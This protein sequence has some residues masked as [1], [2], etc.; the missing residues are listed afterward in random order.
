MKLS[1]KNSK[2]SLS[3]KTLALCTLISFISAQAIVPA[4]TGFAMPTGRQAQNSNAPGG[5]PVPV[6][7]AQVLNG[8]ITVPPELGKIEE[9]FQGNT[10]KTILF[11]QDA[12]DS[13]EAQ[14][15]IARLI[16][17]FVKKNGIKT[18][19]EEGYEGPVPTDKFFGFIKDPKIKQKVSYFLLDKLR[20]GGA[21]YAH[22]NRT[23]DFD[24][25][26][27]D[28]LKLYSEN[29]KAYQDSSKNRKE[30]EDD[31]NELFAQISVLANQYFPKELKSWLRSKERCSKGELPLLDYFKALHSLYLKTDTNSSQFL[32]EYPALSILFA[33]E[34]TKDKKLIVQLN[35]LDS[36]VVFGEMSRLEEK[37]SNAFLQNKR[38]KKI[39]D[40]YQGLSLLKRLNQIQLTQSEYDAAKETLQNFKT[41]ELA[42]FIISLTHK[43]L[44]LSKE[45]ERHIKDAVQFYNVAQTR[46]QSINEHLKSFIKDGKED[47]AALVF[48]GFHATVIK[49]LLKEQGLNYV[50]IFPRIT[51][52]DKIHQ[53]YYRELMSVGHYSFETPFL[54]T[55]ANRPPSVLYTA[56]VA[57]D[58]SLEQE[59]KVIAMAVM[60]L[61]DYAAPQLIEQQLAIS[62]PHERNFYYTAATTARNR[63]ETR[64][65]PQLAKRLKH[66]VDFPN[67]LLTSDQMREI[68]TFVRSGALKL[69]GEDLDVL[70]VSEG[71]TRIVGAIDGMIV[72]LYGLLH[73]SVIVFVVMPDKKLLIMQR[74]PGRIIPP[75]TDR[76][77]PYAPRFSTIGGHPFS[78]ES[79]ERGMKRELVEEIGFPEGWKLEGEM[80]RCGD[81]GVFISPSSD[82]KNRERRSVYIYKPSLHEA[83]IIYERSVALDR[84]KRERS[85][86]EFTQWLHA[87]QEDHPGHGEA[88]SFET[89]PFSDVMEIINGKKIF[90]DEVY[91]NGVKEKVQVI[92]SEDVLPILLK[93]KRIRRFLPIGRSELRNKILSWTIQSAVSNMEKGFVYQCPRT[94]KNLNDFDQAWYD[95]NEMV[96]KFPRILERAS[97]E[98]LPVV[99]IIPEKLDGYSPLADQAPWIEGVRTALAW[100][101][102][103]YRTPS[104]GQADVR[105]LKVPEGFEDEDIILRGALKLFEK[106]IV[107][108][109]SPEDRMAQRIFSL[110]DLVNGEVDKVSLGRLQVKPYTMPQEPE[111]SFSQ[112]VVPELP[113]LR[114][115]QK[116]IVIT[117]AAGLIGV[118][119]IK[120]LLEEGHQVIALD[121]LSR[122]TGEFLTPFLDDSNFYF[123]NLDVSSPFDIQGPVHRVVHLASLAS[124]PDN[125]K[126]PLET[127]RAGLHGTLIT[128]DLARRKGARFLFASSS[129]IY[130]NSKVRPTPETYPGNADAYRKR[131]AYVQS[132]RGGE[133]LMKIYADRWG[134]SVDLRIARIFNVYGPQMQPNDGRVVMNFIQRAMEGQPL[135]V[136]GNN[137]ITRSFNYIDDAVD[138]LLRLL[139]TDRLA[140]GT[141]LE[142]RVF[143]IGNP[144]EITLHELARSV[145]ALAQ[146][147]FGW[148]IPITVVKPLDPDDPLKRQ[149]DITRAQTI[150]DYVPKTS[151]QEGLK[152]TL[153]HFLTGHRRSE[154]RNITQAK[155]SQAILLKDTFK[156]QNS[157]A[158]S[159]RKDVPVD[160]IKGEEQLQKMELPL[161][162]AFFVETEQS[163][164]RLF[165]Y[166][167]VARRTLPVNI[168]VNQIL[169]GTPS[170]QVR[171]K[172]LAIAPKM[173]TFGM[174]FEVLQSEDSDYSDL[175]YRF[176][177]TAMQQGS[178]AVVMLNGFIDYSVDH[179]TR[180]LKSLLSATQPSVIVSH[181]DKV[182]KSSAAAEGPVDFT[183]FADPDFV[184]YRKHGQSWLDSIKP[185]IVLSSMI[186][187]EYRVHSGI[188][189]VDQVSIGGQSARWKVEPFDQFALIP[190]HPPI[191]ERTPGDLDTLLPENETVLFIEPHQDDYALR[192]SGLLQRLAR[193]G[194]HLNVTHFESVTGSESNYYWPPHLEYRDE[195]NRGA[196]SRLGASVDYQ[197]VTVPS[198]VQGHIDQEIQL[199]EEELEKSHANVLVIPGPDDTHRH[200]ARIRYIA[201]SAAQQLVNRTGRPLKI[202]SVPLFSS[203]QEGFRKINTIIRLSD[204]EDQVRREALRSYTSQKPYV[205]GDLFDNR[206]NGMQTV[207]RSLMAE[208][209]DSTKG[210]YLE[211]FQEH[212]L[213]PAVVLERENL[214][215][216]ILSNESLTISFREANKRFAFKFTKGNKEPRFMID[217]QETQALTVDELII[218]NHFTAAFLS[219]VSEMDPERGHSSVSEIET[220]A[221]DMDAINW[222][223]STGAVGPDDTER[224][225]LATAYREI[226][227]RIIGKIEEVKMSQVWFQ[228]R[229]RKF[230]QNKLPQ[231][232]ELY[233]TRLK[234]PHK[235]VIGI[236]TYNSAELI[237][238]RLENIRNQIM[239]LPA[240]CH[241]WQVEIVLYSNAKPADVDEMTSAMIAQ[242]PQSFFDGLPVR[243]TIVIKKEPF[244][245]QANALHR[246]YEYAKQ[247]DADMVL[248]TDD[249]VDYEPGAIQAMIDRLLHSVGPTLVSGRFY[250]R[251]RPVEAL[252]KEAADALRK[253]PIFLSFPVWI[254]GLMIQALTNYKKQWQEIVR[255]RRRPDIPFSPR[256]AMGAGLLMWTDHYAGF[257]YWFPQADVIQRY[258]YFPFI[259][260]VEEAKVSSVAARSFSYLVKK[261]PRSWGR[262]NQINKVFS[263]KRREA[264]RDGDVYYA[265]NIHFFEWVGLSLLDQ[266]YAVANLIV[267]A[268]ARFLGRMLPQKRNHAPNTDERGADTMVIEQG[269]AFMAKILH[270]IPSDW[271]EIRLNVDQVTTINKN[272]RI[273]VIKTQT[274]PVGFKNS[275]L[276]FF[277]RADADPM[278]WPLIPS[279]ILEQLGAAYLAEFG[280]PRDVNIQHLLAIFIIVYAVPDV[281]AADLMRRLNLSRDELLELYGEIQNNQLLQELLTQHPTNRHYFL[282][283]R[284]LLQTKDHIASIL[285]HTATFPLSVE[286]HPSITCNLRCKFCYNRNG[287]FYEEQLR[288]EKILTPDEWRLLVREMAKKGLRRIDLVGGLEPLK[289][290]EASLAIIDEARQQGIK[291]R[292][293]TNGYEL[294]PDDQ[295]IM[296]RLLYSN[297]ERVDISLRGGTAETH[298]DI[299][300]GKDP[301]DFVA[302]KEN[303]RHLVRERN[304]IGSPMK[305]SVNFVLVPDNFHELPE[306]FQL[307][308][309]LGADIIGL[310]TNNIAGRDRLDLSRSEQE[311]LARLLLNEMNKME[312]GERRHFEIGTNE[313][314]DRMVARFKYHGF[315]P[316][317]YRYSFG[318]PTGCLNFFIRPVINPFGNVFKCCVLGQPMIALPI[319]YMGQ[320]IRKGSSLEDIIRVT[321]AHLFRGCPSCNP[322]ERTGL[323]VVEKLAADLKVGI[324]HDKQP[325]RSEMR[326]PPD[327]L[328]ITYYQSKGRELAAHAAR[329]NGQLPVPV[330]DIDR[331]IT[332]NDADLGLSKLSSREKAQ[333]WDLAVAYLKSLQ[334]N[335]G[336]IGILI[337]IGGASSRMRQGP[338]PPLLI[339]AM[340]EAPELFVNPS[341]FTVEEQRIIREKYN[342][343]FS[344]FVRSMDPSSPSDLS[345]L[346]RILY[347]SKAF[348]PAGTSREGQWHGLDEY[349]LRNI[350]AANA[351]LEKLGLG[352][353]FVAIVGTN[354]EFY[355][356]CVD[357]L[358]KHNFYGLKVSTKMDRTGNLDI[359]HDNPANELLLYAG[360]SGFRITAP[361]SVVEKNATLFPTTQAYEHAKQFS[362]IHGGEPITDRSLVGEAAEFLSMLGISSAGR[363][364][365]LL[366]E[367]IRRRIEYGFGRTVDNMAMV[368]ED[369]LTILGY[370]LHKQLSL[371]FE[372]SQRPKGETGGFFAWIR[373]RSTDGSRILARRLLSFDAIQASL[374]EGADIEHL[375][376]NTPINNGSWYF[377][378]PTPTNVNAHAD[379]FSANISPTL[380]NEF[381]R[382]VKTIA[383]TDTLAADF[384]RFQYDLRARSFQTPVLRTIRDP[385]LPN[386]DNNQQ[387]LTVVMEFAEQSEQN[388]LLDR[389]GVVLTPS[390]SDMRTFSSA[391]YLRTRFDPLKRRSTYADPLAQS[392]RE[393]LLRRVIA[394]PLFSDDFRSFVLR[395]EMR[396]KKSIK[397]PEATDI[398]DWKKNVSDKKSSRQMEALAAAIRLQTFQLWERMPGNLSGP[399]SIIDLYAALFLNLIDLKRF[400]A[401]DLHRVRVVLKGTSAF[402]F[403]STAKFAGLINNQLFSN[404]TRENF[405][406]TLSRKM[407]IIDAGQHKLGTSL[408]QGIGMALASKFLGKYFPVVVFLGDGGM[409]LGV[410][411]QAKF[412]AKM[413]L[414]NLAVIVDFNQLQG[415]YRVDQVDDTFSVDRNGSLPRQK[416]I[417]EAYGWEYLEIN[418]HDFGQ[419]E[420]AM[421]QIGK[422]GKPLI[423]FAKTIKG[424][425]MPGIE[426]KLGYAH[427]IQDA[428]ERE[429]ARESL[430]R[431]MRSFQTSGVEASAPTETLRVR[432]K[433]WRRSL[434]IPELQPVAG[435]YLDQTLS[436]WFHK[437]LDL[438]PNRLM[439]LNTDN[440]KPFKAD[441]PIYTPTRQSPFVFLGVNERFALNLARGL[442]EGG[443]FPTYMTPTAHML[444][445][446][447]DWRY[448]TMEREPILLV[449]YFPGSSI[450]HWGPDHSAYE[451]IDL[452]KNPGTTVYQPATHQDLLIIL[453]AIYSQP[454]E[455]LPA[456]IRLPEITNDLANPGLYRTERQRDQILKSGFYVMESFNSHTPSPLVILISSG[457]LLQENLKA[458]DQLRKQGIS[459]KVV[460]VVNLSRINP[461]LLKKTVADASLILTSIDARPSS[462]SS[463]VFEAV[464]P[465]DRAKVRALGISGWGGYGKPEEIYKKA[466]L[467]ATGISRR[468]MRELKK[469]KL[470]P[471]KSSTRNN[472]SA[473]SEL[474]FLNLASP[475]SGSSL[476]IIRKIKNNTQPTTVFLDAADFPNLSEM[477]KREYFFVALSRSETRIIVYNENGQVHDKDLA[478]L[479]KLDRVERTVWGLDQTVRRFANPHVSAIQL[480]KDILP[481][482]TEIQSLRNRVA[483][484]KTIGDKSGTLAT[485]LLWAISGGEKVHMAGVREEDGFWTVEESLLDALQ[486]TYDNNFVIAVAA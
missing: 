105:V 134:Q 423:I 408:E 405:P 37:L 127:I 114:K 447:E 187:P 301:R 319:G 433:D 311:E 238:A 437:L 484:F 391:D 375:L 325:V 202:I 118:A 164:Q 91:K 274:F 272:G 450:A 331:M 17:Q 341:Q 14:E 320:V 359:D 268:V 34:A 243:T 413:H 5:D 191:G 388:G 63:A 275:L 210:L 178:R 180:S 400:A 90:R 373:N 78:G 75:N 68:L 190:T 313:S 378:F 205:E 152:K 43:S 163:V 49:E 11:I 287:Q 474:R 288:G 380:R 212:W 26:G 278:D 145:Q 64:M 142:E 415:S 219:L 71:K 253:H 248:F 346:D 240:Y 129:E 30:T 15:N 100:A 123:K 196:F 372:T 343:N 317:I 12:H 293:F 125:F 150:L 69:A 207:L 309:E 154:I 322:A 337:L 462:L 368:N 213:V 364:R 216:Q 9:S 463:L 451:D 269:N 262:E 46:D 161:S 172:I 412:A 244:P 406:P 84:A 452:F 403:Y 204:G 185:Y 242:I 31:L 42:D 417:W 133:T 266:F 7:T 135:E 336:K 418:G 298:L 294:R 112:T 189:D 430:E 407:K 384:E 427:R 111:S 98:K 438:N 87:Q 426:G 201:L 394:G 300:G 237:A 199:F 444:I 362:L 209:S 323:A 149:P 140:P 92:F 18:V 339:R 166:L 206:L 440:P 409:Q 109:G 366:A 316:A 249:D 52:A 335:G 19:F 159:L 478:A 351:E 396:N 466:Q 76:T 62:I 327:N 35:A 136:Y 107:E 132:K 284:G 224:R 259:E 424:K 333:Y 445:N 369:W 108:G 146:K 289:N 291:L 230:F 308:D 471:A 421:G 97:K 2:A 1:G 36:K 24:L 367:L 486:R 215:I 165:D 67:P 338:L 147:L 473:R 318:L 110:G 358:S 383:Q 16:N 267:I 220:P 116:R 419:I 398:T 197:T 47:A 354:D 256:V 236:A 461:A 446:A 334:K 470:W 303:I 214:A 44:V 310:G 296:Q 442:S 231:N 264:Q 208:R 225:N 27:V 347:A 363:K 429:R 82:L 305:V 435:N 436:A 261:A 218:L 485:A 340:R 374:P 81:E 241:S 328:R 103:Y 102:A 321:A 247:N 203:G 80:Q 174:E 45:W 252:R 139:E 390:V 448:A 393:A 193:R 59:L 326:A 431:T 420:K 122:G 141:P 176:Q 307:V 387:I 382:L 119:M 467:D 270:P 21:E 379:I 392:V 155:T 460:N 181:L 57:G 86:D 304:R 456:Y 234:K 254:Q 113:E 482:S 404:P 151:L 173:E 233:Q 285:D 186:F 306:M 286:V 188:G 170:R 457:A 130:G 223:I 342:G 281:R 93:D 302:L 257:P 371:V 350:S 8:T 458:A 401:D 95:F 33:A 422:T 94:P 479:L 386:A 117:G 194:N 465:D 397:S 168:K 126:R 160:L 25:I 385:F 198:D 282:R 120:R 179:L 477:Q 469:Q 292:V 23:Q 260:V 153:E 239:E 60:T 83:K 28:S 472:E 297:V 432:R 258:R 246:A 229:A 345:V 72:H 101:S 299:V 211:G 169:I 20:L 443:V 96:F 250:W 104:L 416:K 381:S 349:G 361:L 41:H 124:P 480:S 441:V 376:Q 227:E 121:N 106:K 464:S 13:L 399:M 312:T 99:L 88:W 475:I 353:P 453:K 221:G 279:G 273:Q 228:E 50:V 425:G 356:L 449:G 195:E 89:F 138:G 476:Q 370:M 144:N 3:L 283:L 65:I 10:K 468:V 251:A 232:A 332:P 315:L 365:P 314:I 360:S 131:S 377:R 357:R 245:N 148:L 162:I 183:F 61:G 459:Y 167:K 29:I 79:D 143:N 277:Q 265:R 192:S 344:S 74:V 263:E 276:D 200:H 355:P 58:F 402:G 348:L 177:E 352:R 330:F 255:F 157:E 439:V 6:S 51:K 280:N 414:N 454:K 324:P 48:G 395:S 226:H 411:H 428:N 158:G 290:K 235:L 175:M 22:V 70:S 4:P 56:T 54:V 455:F 38:D 434:R 32:K 271:E 481:S 389:T 156:I 222:L 483:F 184:K 137:Q 40:Y 39:F 171:E 73:R 329:M 217:D 55:R 77:K 85:K 128:M 182:K 53:D 115:G 295:D 410:D 66:L